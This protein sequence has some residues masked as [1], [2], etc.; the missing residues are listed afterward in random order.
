MKK[1]TLLLCIML[2]VACSGKSND[3]IVLEV[4][5]GAGIK[6]EVTFDVSEYSV[7]E[8]KNLNLNENNDLRQLIS[9]SIGYVKGYLSVHLN[10]PSSYDYIEDSIG[11]IY[12]VNDKVNMS[13]NFT[14]Q[15]GFGAKIIHKAFLEIYKQNGELQVDVKIQ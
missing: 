10:N 13:F 2:L 9:Y 14:E 12:V 3:L 6:K 15:N 8:I 4:K 5:N 11:D 7:N 1:I